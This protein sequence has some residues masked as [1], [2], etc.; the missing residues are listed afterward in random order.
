MDIN[1]HVSFGE[2][3]VV[4]VIDRPGPG[5]DGTE[6][7]LA[8]LKPI[9]DSMATLA[10]TVQQLGADDATLLEDVDGLIAII[11]GIP[12][13][14]ATAVAAALAAA[15]VTDTQQ[16]A[17]LAALD[18]SVQA[19]I[20][21][22][23]ALLPSPSNSGNLT[24]GNLTLPPATI[25]EPYTATIA[26]GGGVAPLDLTGQGWPTGLNVDSGGNVSG[27]PAGS[28]TVGVTTVA[29]TLEDSSDP[30]PLE[31]VANA[32]I[33]VL[34]AAPPASLSISPS[35]GSGA[36]GTPSAI[37]VSLSGGTGPYGLV[38]PPQGVTFD[39]SNLNLDDTVVAGEVEVEF[40]DS[41]EPTPLTVNF[42]LTVSAPSP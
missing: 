3:R 32:T 14:T 2:L 20:A 22:A 28:A 24:L 12:A 18:T 31:L 13:K 35:S 15:G 23:A 30:T 33:Q 8:A 38:N 5:P 26:I 17:I 37:A 9:G 7:I 6:L 27:T 41:T 36:A 4:H 11:N 25:G 34:A 29:L 19:E 39:G 1:L 10:Q 16:T 42:D 40:E 21:K